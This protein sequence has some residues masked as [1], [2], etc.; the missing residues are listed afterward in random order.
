MNMAGSILIIDDDALVRGTLADNLRDSGF[1]VT[2]A[3]DG[4]AALGMIVSG[5]APAVVITDIV[6]PRKDGLE[7][8]LDLRRLYPDIK[9]IAISGG[10]RRGGLDFLEMAG[11]LGADAVLPKPLD[12]DMLE[13]TVLRFGAAPAP[14]SRPAG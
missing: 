9:V 8:I 12:L 1:F 13:A 11:K 3:G 4:M 7:T 14:L 5:Q 6:M 2:T 10:A